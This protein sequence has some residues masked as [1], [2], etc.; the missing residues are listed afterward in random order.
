MPRTKIACLGAGSY[1]FPRALGNMAITEGLAGSEVTLYDLDFEKA[2][3]MARLGRRLAK[4][5]GTGVKVRACAELADAIDGADFAVSSI[6]GSGPS[7][8]GVYGTEVHRA[9]MV[10]PARYGIYQIVGDTGGPAGMMMGLRSVPV[11]LSI[12]REME[13]R[14]PDVVVLNHSNP[15][16]VLCRAMLKYSGIQKVIGICHGVQGGIMQVAELLGVEPEALE[17]VWIGTNHYYW[18][19]RIRLNGKDVYDEVMTKAKARRHPHGEI[20]SAKLSEAYGYRL[21]YQEDGHAL[22][23]YPYLAQVRDPMSIPY[24]YAEEVGARYED[25]SPK[26]A[27][28]VSAKE[29]AAQRKEG[30]KEFAA[31]L[32]GYSLPEPE[33]SVIRGEGIASL[34]EAIATGERHVRIVNIPNRGVVPNLPDYAVLEVEGVTDSCGVRGVH[35]GEAPVS[36]MGLLQKRIAWQELVADAAATGDRKLALQ[37]LLLDE[38]AI[39]PEQ[40]EAMLDELLAASKALLP[41]FFGRRG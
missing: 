35:A 14:C 9:D 1:Y 18:F 39:A 22:E 37:A 19:T 33:V 6:G 23:F 16:A 2:Q 40:S 8:G 30:L 26:P 24:G 36:L 3:I 12:C 32:K 38:M 28:K 21:V 4:E 11:Y 31:R 10:I 17:T 5:S 15:M 29:R 13:K 34:I 20:M 7:L 27:P 25:L 41:Q